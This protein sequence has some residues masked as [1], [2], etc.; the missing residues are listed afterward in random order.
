MRKRLQNFGNLAGERR[1][2]SASKVLGGAGPP[3]RPCEALQWVTQRGHSVRGVAGTKVLGL[4][5]SH[6]LRPA[7]Y[8]AGRGRP[9]LGFGIPGLPGAGRRVPCCGLGA[10]LPPKC[11]GVR[12][13]ENSCRHLG[14]PLS[15]GGLPSEW[16]RPGV[17]AGQKK[18]FLKLFQHCFC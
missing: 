14:H 17:C 4:W 18:Y 8:W 1:H 13:H 2:K 15:G 7:V 10:G 9:C 5:R 6:S 16:P 3:Y 12:L 11:F